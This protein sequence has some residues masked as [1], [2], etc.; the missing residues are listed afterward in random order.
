MDKHGHGHGD[1]R[2]KSGKGGKRK[3]KLKRKLNELPKIYDP[4]P[5][6]KT[7]D[8]GSQRYFG[9]SLQDYSPNSPKSKKGIH[10]RSFGRANRGI[11]G[12]FDISNNIGT[13]D[14]S[15]N[16]DST[17]SNRNRNFSSFSMRSGLMGHISPASSKPSPT[18]MERLRYERGENDNMNQSMDAIFCFR[19]KFIYQLDLYLI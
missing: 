5:D 13:N 17:N 18:A 16:V 15:N 14:N 6:M 7:P 11:L 12:Y 8:R 2:R 1:D 9:H 4:D 10:I 19:N 3:S